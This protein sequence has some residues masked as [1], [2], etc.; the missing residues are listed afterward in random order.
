MKDYKKLLDDYQKQKPN[1]EGIEKMLYDGFDEVIRK[2][3]KIAAQGEVLMMINAAIMDNITLR[4]AYGKYCVQRAEPS[5]IPLKLSD[6]DVHSY[7]SENG[8]LLIS[9]VDKPTVS[10]EFYLKLVRRPQ[11]D[12][13]DD[14][15]ERIRDY[16]LTILNEKMRE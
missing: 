11:V 12:I 3:G 16:V 4:E 6:M 1:M 14:L 10:Y 15:W 9:H 5:E 7:E 2:S 13:S 8:K